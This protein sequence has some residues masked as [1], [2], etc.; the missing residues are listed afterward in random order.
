MLAILFGLLSIGAF[1]QDLINAE[2]LTAG[3]Y[4]RSSI[5][6]QEAC[7]SLAYES[8]KQGCLEEI[9]TGSFQSGALGLCAAFQ[10]SVDCFT[11]IRDKNYAPDVLSGCRAF[12]GSNENTFLSCIASMPTSNTT[13]LES[14]PFVVEAKKKGSWN[15]AYSEVRKK[16]KSECSY[17]N[18]FVITNPKWKKD[19]CNWSG[20][21]VC[22]R[23]VQGGTVVINCYTKY[24]YSCFANVVCKN[25]L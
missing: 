22:E 11:L 3:D 23:I 10:S 13:V 25:T 20:E 17:W 8:L 12:I 21:Q 18:Y 19:E 9:K 24:S 5:T 2:D 1:A 15:D 7:A 4:G 16:A 14:E 6:P